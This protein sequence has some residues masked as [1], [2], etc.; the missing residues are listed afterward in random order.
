MAPFPNIQVSE[1]SLGSATSAEP[2]D[3]AWCEDQ[4]KLML[5]LLLFWWWYDD[6]DLYIYRT[7]WYSMYSMYDDYDGGMFNNRLMYVCN[8]QNPHHI[9][10]KQDWVQNTTESCVPKP[11]EGLEE[12][13]QE[14]FSVWGK[15]CNLKS[16]Q[17]YAHQGSSRYWRSGT[18]NSIGVRSQ[19]TN[20]N[21]QMMLQHLRRWTCNGEVWGDPESFQCMKA[22]LNVALVMAQSG[23]TE[24]TDTS[25]LY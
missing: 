2:L 21:S 17:V 10:I 15:D 14:S 4:E 16:L 5:Q 20:F 22:L 6:T 13:V 8:V 24:I 23:S 25:N 11:I 7:V 1:Q 18:S 3:L 12:A 9:H 19:L